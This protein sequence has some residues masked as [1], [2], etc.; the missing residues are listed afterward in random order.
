M[1]F[2]AE[3]ILARM[4]A[5]LKNEDTKMEGSFS[6]DNLQAVAEEVARLNAMRIVPLL[7]ALADRED[8]MGTSGNEKHYIKWAKEAVDAEGK[9]IVGNA[10]VNKVR[11]GTGLVSIAILT[12]DAQPP[13]EGQIRIVQEYIDGKR[14]VG[15]CPIVSAAE[16]IDIRVVCTVK[17]AA[18][19]ANETVSQG[20]KR[21]LQLHFTESAFQT[22]VLVLNYYQLGNIISA[23]E[24]VAELDCLTVNGKQ[25][26][27]MADY[28]RYFTLKEAIVNVTE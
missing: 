18:G 15:A 17:K 19:Y 10:K 14:P 22:G 1:D 27:I 5:D 4:K 11:D 21:R 13:T 3:G 28:N 20:I 7:N 16:G 6:M 24:G 23:T 12:E 26:S 8:D 2:S 25:E 9:R